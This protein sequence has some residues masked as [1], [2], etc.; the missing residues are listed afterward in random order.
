MRRDRHGKSDILIDLTSLLDV[1]FIL[2][3][4]VLAKQQVSGME[5]EKKEVFI[6]ELQSSLER[7]EAEELDKLRLY[8]DQI[9]TAEKTVIISVTATFNPVEPKQ[10]SLKILKNGNTE[11][12]E[13]I[14]SG[15]DT[16]E[17]YEAFEK[18]LREYVSSPE[19]MPVILSIADDGSEILYRDQ[20][21]IQ[22]IFLSLQKGS[23]DIYIRA[24]SEDREE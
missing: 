21:R 19:G 3:M 18:K 7:T 10:R 12:D 20:K 16:K 17:A 8:T 4:V 1:I 14:L 9:D 13:F 6:S 2:L 11:A 15:G 24:V 22:E 5:L 23:D